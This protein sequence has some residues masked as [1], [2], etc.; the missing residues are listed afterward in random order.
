M[1]VWFDWNIAFL[2]SQNMYFCIFKK[3]LILGLLLDESSKPSFTWTLFEAEILIIQKWSVPVILVSRNWG[4]KMEYSRLPWITE[5]DSISNNKWKKNLSYTDKSHELVLVSIRSSGFSTWQS[6]IPE[7]FN[8]R[9]AY[10]RFSHPETNHNLSIRWYNIK[11]FL[12]NE[13]KGKYYTW[14]LP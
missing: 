9:K 13:G 12:G 14:S 5:R 8:P 11:V 1:W 6:H 3:W 4:K 7:R 10:A 2:K